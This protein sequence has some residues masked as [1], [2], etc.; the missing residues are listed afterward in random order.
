MFFFSM[1][2]VDSVVDLGVMSQLLIGWL[3]SAPM[4]AGCPYFGRSLCLPLVFSAALDVPHQVPF[5]N[6]F[7]DPVLSSPLDEAHPPSGAPVHGKR[8]K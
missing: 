6:T 2:E 8:E 1:G 5:D 7:C 4:V 3:S